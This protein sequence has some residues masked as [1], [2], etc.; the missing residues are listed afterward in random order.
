MSSSV[1]IPLL[2]LRKWLQ[3]E[4]EP[5]IKPLRDK[6]EKLLD[7]IKDRLDDVQE[8]GDRLFT[9]SDKEV[10]KGS[11]KTYRCAKA[12]NKMSKNISDIIN[13]IAVPDN[14]SIENIQSLAEDLEKS[15]AAIEQERRTWYRRISPY[16]ILD[17]RRL[18]IS[19]K[20]TEDSIRE[21]RSFLLSEYV[22]V[23][24]AKNL[25]DDIDKLSQLLENAEKRQR[26]I[27]KIETRLNLHEEKIR[28]ENQKIGLITDKTEL[29]ELAELEQRIIEL[30][31]KVKHSLRHLRKPFYKMQSLA[32]RSQVALPPDEVRKLKQ[33]MN[34]P[35][36]ALVSEEYGHP[37]LKRI[38]QKLDDTM[39]RGKLKL[40]TTR[41]R[42]AQKQMDG[43]LRKNSL[44]N[45]HRDCLA[46]VSRK[47]QLSASQTVTATQKEV[48]Q[49]QTVLQK[50]QT[51]KES[52]ES[53][54]RVLKEEHQRILKK[55]ESQKNELEKSILELVDKTVQ[56]VLTKANKAN[57]NI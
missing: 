36:E 4:T 18:D 16:F 25:S 5:I 31:A 15:F 26:L 55:I 27:N 14:V 34:N 6:G 32:L 46:V 44:F 52:L 22:D 33:Y 24:T 13:R 9:K 39:V 10:Q 3:S 20:R 35:F 37:V 41:F 23:E 40:K 54:R 7:E 1:K 2:D 53:R 47:R 8:N 38:L 48:D 21:L 30:G 28:K 12:A 11:A 17:R 42:K 43:I 50:L 49:L 56:V 57:A 51:Q 45:L 19:I 29:D